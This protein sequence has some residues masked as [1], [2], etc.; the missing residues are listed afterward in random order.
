M[1]KSHPV[2]ELETKAMLIRA[3]VNQEQNGSVLGGL[4][5]G[6]S[7]LL[8]PDAR[9]VVHEYGEEL[10]QQQTALLPAVPATGA[11]LISTTQRTMLLHPR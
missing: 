11:I 5:K 9:S 4:G 3:K 7:C 8:D 10:I 1:E 2:S 6:S